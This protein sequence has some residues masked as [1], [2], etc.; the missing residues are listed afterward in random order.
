[1]P[2][3]GKAVQILLSR[4]GLTGNKSVDEIP[5]YMMV[6]PCRN[7]NIH[8]GGREKRGGTSKK[9]STAFSGSP[10]IIGLCDYTNAS[11]TQFLVVACSDQKI[12]KN[13]TDTIA[14]DMGGGSYFPSFE[15]VG[16]TLF[17]CDGS[18]TP[19]SW[20]GGAGNFT[21]FANP[22]AD[23]TAN[24]PFQFVKHG[25]GNSERLWALNNA[26]VYASANGDPDEFVT[27][28]LVFPIETSERYG[29][30]GMT[31]FRENLYIFGRKKT[32]IIDDS[33]TSTDNWGY[34]AAPWEG[35]AGNSRL[36]IKLPSDL[37]CM[38]EDGEIYS[39]SAVSEYGDLRA[40]SLIRP[41]FMHTFIRDNVNLA[42]INKFHGIFD[43]IMRAIKFFVVRSGQTDVDTALVMFLD[44]PLEEAWVIHDNIPTTYHG[45]K[46]ASSAI[47]RKSVGDMKIYTGD[48]SGYVWELETADYNDDDSGYYGGFKTPP[49]HFDDPRSNKWFARCRVIGQPK[50]GYYLQAKTIID[51]VAQGGNQLLS[52]Q[53]SGAV[54]GE[55]L[56]D[57]DSLGGDEILEVDFDIAE[58]G[59]RL[60]NEFYNANADETFFIS[61]L[62]YDI[63]PL[64]AS[65]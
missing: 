56:L 62:I 58:R 11:G 45:Y 23:W 28:V 41:S 17:V 46:A 9:Y 19:K 44:R 61:E 54:L 4:G 15:I 3:R 21:N 25:R 40:A 43:P 39:V 22:A 49:M 2:L 10:T 52:M 26:K 48:Y 42:Q 36:I 64:G 65:I 34:E 63:K 6:E 57:T 60:Q 59:K 5:N 8:N 13:D 53:G 7:I 37:V 14:T 16:N 35:G 24:P 55:F 1:M 47:V 50:G 18:V 20:D 31:E 29:L 38:T 12:Y 27:G 51:G 30:V 32:Y 33:D